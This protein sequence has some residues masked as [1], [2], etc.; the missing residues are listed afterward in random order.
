MM[1]RR[2][3]LAARA[4][5]ACWA[6][7]ALLAMLVFGGEMLT[8]PDRGG[9]GYWRGADGMPWQS[10]PLMME[11]VRDITALGGVT[12]R[13]LLAT[14]LVA[15][16]VAVGRRRIAIFYA[17]TVLGG[18]GVGYAL[19][20]LFA[21]IRPDVVPHLMHADGYSFPS[22]HAFNSAT[23][24]IAAALAF[25]AH[26]RG[27]RPVLLTASTIIAAL[28]AFSRVWLGVHYPS[29][30]MA[31]FLGGTA[32]ALM[33]APFYDRTVDATPLRGRFPAAGEQ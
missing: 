12:V 19:K 9:L 26:R 3:P 30:V 33:A 20:L 29:D 28:V 13:L 18:W 27:L 7:F 11:A 2:W 4:A 23:V 6:G 14:I 1:I 32:C 25:S 10:Q 31:G 15:I 16:L 5:L 21:R 22:G 24:F 8:G 17:A